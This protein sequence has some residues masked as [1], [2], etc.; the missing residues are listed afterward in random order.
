MSIRHKFPAAAQD[1]SSV[2]IARHKFC[3]SRHEL[4]CGSTKHDY[5]D[6]S[7]DC[8]YS[9]N[10]P[11]VEPLTCMQNK[12]DDRSVSV[13]IMNS[14][15]SIVSLLFAIVIFDQRRN[16]PVGRPSEAFKAFIGMSVTEKIAMLKAGGVTVS[17]EEA[18]SYS[19]DEWTKSFDEYK[20]RV[21]D[22]KQS[23]GSSKSIVKEEGKKSKR[24]LPDVKKE[25][26]SKKTKGSVDHLVD[27]Y[28]GK[29]KSV[30][31]YEEKS[32]V[33]KTD[34]DI[35]DE[36]D[37]V[38][39]INT[40]ELAKSA[41][42][43]SKKKTFAL[44]KALNILLER[45]VLNTGEL[46][47]EIHDMY[48]A[49]RNAINTRIDHIK[50]GAS[51]SAGSNDGVIDEL[52]KQL[53]KSQQELKDVTRKNIRMEMELE[54]LKEKMKEDEGGSKKGGDEKEGDEKEEEGSKKD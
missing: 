3:Q 32:V 51:T 41:H 12:Q 43:F 40:Y 30:V 16:M 52:R 53:E 27:D 7:N 1:M 18:V 13:N 9:L 10:L 22:G 17:K 42:M 20:A 31:D 50:S 35:E 54:Q 37:Q 44:L 11:Q 19:T 28:I 33:F 5:I 15:H 25:S 39:D 26:A 49:A 21:S 2:T 24:P 23:K 8:I 29:I 34:S 14:L 48:D 4:R 36:G 6:L 38:V 45:E 46:P 47:Q